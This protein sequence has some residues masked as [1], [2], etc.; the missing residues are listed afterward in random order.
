MSGWSLAVSILALAVAITAASYTRKQ[1]NLAVE[2][3][4]RALAL[5]APSLDIV[6]TQIDERRWKLEV[7]L[8]NRSD[9]RIQNVGL[10][11]PSPEGGFI[12]MQQ[13]EPS[14]Q[15]VMTIEINSNDHSDFAGRPIKPG[16]VGIWSAGFE[17][18]SAFA[19]KPGTIITMMMVIKFLGGVER[20]R[21]ISVTRQL[22]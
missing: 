11:I 1:Y 20:T 4:Q 6:P 15:P 2:Q 14:G 18:S 19:A 3:D 7:R 22:N 13:T 10:T 17:I 21:K 9:E 8:H 12:S 5:K 16:E